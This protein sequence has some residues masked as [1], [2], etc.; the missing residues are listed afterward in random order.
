LKTAREMRA[1]EQDRLAAK[2]YKGAASAP[3]RETH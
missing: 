2:V 1:A 3:P